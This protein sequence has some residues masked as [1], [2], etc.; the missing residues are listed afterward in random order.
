MSE[1]IREL[2][3]RKASI[4]KI[5]KNLSENGF[6]TIFE[7]G[8]RAAVEGNFFLEEVKSVIGEVR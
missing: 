5:R 8:L 7:K 2:I 4:S 1:K 6:V 3:I